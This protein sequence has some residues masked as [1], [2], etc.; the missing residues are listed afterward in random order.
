MTENYLY[1][2]PVLLHEAVEALQIVPGGIYVDVTFGGGGHSKAILDKLD[3]SGR[4]I[5][6]DQDQDALQNTIEDKRFTLVSHN[7]K[8]LKR[9]LRMYGI[10]EVNGIL[11]DLGVSWHQF[12][13]PDRGF[14]LRFGNEQLD[15]RMSADNELSAIEVLNKYP[16]INLSHIFKEYGDLPNARK[17]AQAVVH[18]RQ[19]RPIETIQQLLVLAEPLSIG[20][21]Q[22][23]FARVFQAVRMEVNKEVEALQSLLEQSVEVL[24]PGGLLVVISYHSVEDRM[25]KNYIKTGSID[26]IV[27]TDLYGHGNIPLAV[28]N[29]NLITPTESEIRQNPKASSAKM[30]IAQKK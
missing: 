28:V 17:L 26:G 5:A 29:K 22:Q 13:T 16:M 21:P 23:Y 18:E 10:S 2:Q 20:K 6:F 25:V 27:K 9:F 12:N 8:H 24:K 1:H 11:A 19:K 4:L 7:F 15:M 14:S 30:R 3:E